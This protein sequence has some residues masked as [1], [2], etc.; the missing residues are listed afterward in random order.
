MNQLATRAP[1]QR[2]VIVVVAHPRTLVLR[3]LTRAPITF[4]RLV[5]S[6]ISTSSGGTEKPWT[7]PDQTSARMGLKP[8]KFM[9]TASVVTIAIIA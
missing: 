9:P 6:I 4:L 1:V 8:R 3:E 5:R 2:K 7:T